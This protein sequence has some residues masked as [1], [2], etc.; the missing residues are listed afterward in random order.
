MAGRGLRPVLVQGPA[1]EE[2]VAMVLG[3]IGGDVPP[4]LSG[5]PVCDLA[6]LLSLCAAYLGND[7]GVTHLAAAAG[8][9]AVALFGPTDPAVWGPRGPRATIL[10]GEQGRLESISVEMVVEALAA[11]ASEG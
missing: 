8:T 1:D 11:Q 6:A 5:L 4:V 7:S 3:T 2:A 9:P 10:R